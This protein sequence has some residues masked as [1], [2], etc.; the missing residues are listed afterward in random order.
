MRGIL[1]RLLALPHVVRVTDKAA[2]GDALARLGVTPD[3]RCATSSTLRSGAT[4]PY[5][6]TDRPVRPG[7]A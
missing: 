3:A 1:A 2:I 7:R 5:L 4:V 6:G